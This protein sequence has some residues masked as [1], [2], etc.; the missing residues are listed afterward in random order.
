MLPCTGEYKAETQKIGFDVLGSDIPVYCLNAKTADGTEVI[1]LGD[2]TA[3]NSY[4]GSIVADASGEYVAYALTDGEYSYTHIPDI[5]DTEGY[6]LKAD[7]IETSLSEAFWQVYYLTAEAELELR[8]TT[9]QYADEFA[10]YLGLE[11]DAYA[12]SY[13]NA[14]VADNNIAKLTLT[15]NR[16]TAV[17]KLNGELRE[18]NGKFDADLFAIGDTRVNDETKVYDLRKTDY[19]KTFAS[20]AGYLVDNA[21]Y[22]GYALVDENGTCKAYV[23]SEVVYNNSDD[24][25]IAIVTKV[26]YGTAENLLP[27]VSAYALSGG[28][29]GSSSSGSSGNSSSS[30]GS[31]PLGSMTVPAGTNITEAISV[32][33]VSYIQDEVE[34]TAVFFGN[35]EFTSASTSVGLLRVGDLLTLI[36]DSNGVAHKCAVLGTVIPG[37]ILTLDA[38]GMAASGYSANTK[39][40]YGY[41]SSENWH[42]TSN[43]VYFEVNVDGEELIYCIEDNTNKYTYNDTN[44]KVCIEIEDFMAGDVDCFDPDTNEASMVFIKMTDDVVT[45]IYS[46]SERVDI[47]TIK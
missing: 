47:T 20:N 39:L 30:S 25:N 34:K 41:I 37:D 35:T 3:G 17:N 44:A 1:S 18:C 9:T 26:A 28:S 15:D 42:K 23:I 46:F 4:S 19:T 16:I 7:L 24:N 11:A 13:N 2:L 27:A 40:L 5:T 22:T 10:S 8:N 21:D 38:E 12:Y 33:K 45:D 32:T 6:I 14:Y 36:T 31:V 29:S 43:R